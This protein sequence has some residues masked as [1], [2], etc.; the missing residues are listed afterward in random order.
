M[1][2]L[3]PVGP[4]AG[5]VVNL[6]WPVLSAGP[7]EYFVLAWL[8]GG[9]PTLGKRSNDHLPVDPTEQLHTR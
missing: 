1:I 8:H 6:A 3:N 5:R 2:W 4:V 7:H 9:D